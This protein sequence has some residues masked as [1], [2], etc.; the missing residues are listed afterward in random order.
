MELTCVAFESA[1]LDHA[2]L[3]E[4]V[5]SE[6]VVADL[7]GVLNFTRKRM[8]YVHQVVALVKH[9]V[10]FGTTLAELATKGTLDAVLDNLRV[11]L[12]ANLVHIVFSDHFV[13]TRCGRLQI[14]QRV[15]HVALSSKDERLD[16]F[17]IGA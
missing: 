5:E 3:L 17:F 2:G 6:D 9:F 16:T 1:H 12:V 15:P 11:W 4:E 8:H 10:N 7:A 13:E 14:V